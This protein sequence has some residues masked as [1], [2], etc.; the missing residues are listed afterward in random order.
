MSELINTPENRLAK[1]IDFANGMVN[2]EN[3]VQLYEIYRHITDTVTPTE[4]MEVLDVLLRKGM[5][6]EKLKA[7]LGKIIN[8]FY[9]SLEAFD[10]EKPDAGHFLHH[11]MLENR[12]V[13]RIM[14]GIKSISKELF[15]SPTPEK[16]QSL[17]EGLNALLPYELHYIKKENILFPYIEKAF[18]GYRCLSIM[19]SFH[20]DFRSS[21][22]TLDAMLSQAEIDPKKL[23]NELGKLFF[24]VYPIIFRE[25]HIVFPV[26]LRAIPESGWQD[27]M[28]QSFELGWCYIDEPKPMEASKHQ[29]SEKTGLMDLE[30]GLL[31][32]EQVILLLN[33]IPVDVTFIDEN[34][35]VR[36]FS[37]GTHRIFPRS[38]AIIGRKVQNCH[39]PESV[40]MVN[41]I[42]DAFKNGE[43]DHA[44]FWITIKGKFLHIRYFAVRDDNG[45]YKGTLEVS[46]DVT[47]I[48]ALEGQRRLLEWE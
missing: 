36:Y 4:A 17:R 5:A 42:V 8:V 16:Y 10:W 14:E 43:R 40:H 31:S 26:A 15:G 9:K 44:E 34:D 38:K 11:L 41:Q 18:P 28:V 7:A 25:E 19:W 1:L 3:G 12:E 47:D 21:L 22:K 6:P 23:S 2:G 30:T 13:E 39:P 46:Q 35:E 45:K 20:D 24:T 29:P 48:R 33:N 37:G 27:M 32:V